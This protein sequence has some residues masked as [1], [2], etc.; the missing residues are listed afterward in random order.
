[1]FDCLLT[2]PSGVSSIMQS[3]GA[4]EDEKQLAPPGL[5]CLPFWHQ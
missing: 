3:W 5:H 2:V 4:D 1:M